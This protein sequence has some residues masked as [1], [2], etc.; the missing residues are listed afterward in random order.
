[1]RYFNYITLRIAFYLLIYFSV[2]LYTSTKHFRHLER[3][4]LLL[5]CVIVCKVI[6]W[7]LC[8]LKR[9]LDICN[10]FILQ[11]M[12]INPMKRWFF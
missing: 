6:R 11:H 10:D 9:D 3:S 5:L 4:H 12:N 8:E 2:S 7:T 1:M